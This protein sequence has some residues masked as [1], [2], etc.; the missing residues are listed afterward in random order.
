MPVRIAWDQYEVALLID[1]YV[2]IA[3]GANLGETA[4]ALSKSL[5]TLARSRGI[6]ID[7]LYRNVNG[8]KMQLA[9]VKY[10]FTNGQSGLSG[11]SELVQHMYKLYL[12]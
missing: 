7:D 2:R 5:R 1:A 6:D 12:Q 8:I 10:L 3:S 11:A 9:D 4:V